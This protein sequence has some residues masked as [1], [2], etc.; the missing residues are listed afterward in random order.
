MSKQVIY[1]ITKDD[2]ISSLWQ[3]RMISED[4]YRQ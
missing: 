1:K 2:H 3:R 4:V